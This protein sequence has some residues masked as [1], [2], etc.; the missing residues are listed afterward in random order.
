TLWPE[1]SRRR[2]IRPC[3]GKHALNRLILQKR[4]RLAPP[5]LEFPVSAADRC[6]HLGGKVGFL[7]LDALAE[8]VAHESRQRD[9]RTH[10]ALGFLERLGDRLRRIVDEGLVEEADLLVVGLEA[11]L[12]DIP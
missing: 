6:R 2:A 8:A 3:A 5:F 7:F 12:D 1:H 9:G 4:R 10:L 11:A